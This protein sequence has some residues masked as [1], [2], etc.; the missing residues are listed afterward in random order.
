MKSPITNLSARWLLEPNPTRLASP[1]SLSGTEWQTYTF[2][3]G[4]GEGGYEKS[5]LALGMSVFLGKHLFTPQALG[6]MI[7]LAE[8]EVQFSEPTFQ[9]QV[10]RG[11]RIMHKEQIPQTDLVYSP[12]NDLF[13]LAQHIRQTPMLDGSSNSEMFALTVA[14]STLQT[15]LGAGL[16][17]QLLAQLGLEKAPTVLV[18]PVPIHVTKPLLACLPST[19]SGDFRKV[20]CQ[21]KVLEYLTRLVEHYGQDQLPTKPANQRN[22]AHEV[23]DYLMTHEGTLPLLSKLAQ[24]FN[25]PARALNQEFAQEYG[26]SIF[27]FITSK[28]LEAARLAILESDTSLKQLAQKLGYSHVNHFS[29]AFTKKYGYGPASL[30]KGRLAEQ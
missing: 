1:L 9:V 30:R 23:H 7:A 11:G 3:D 8:F 21:T 15:L 25:R 24:S 18:R 12:G 27:S 16:T 22:R 10:V 5:V 2:P 29:A 26:E 20:F 19:L 14:I 28:R 17:E 6:H 13:R 4:L